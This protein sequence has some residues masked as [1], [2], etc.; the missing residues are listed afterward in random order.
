MLYVRRIMMNVCRR[1]SGNTNK[2]AI[3]S[4]QM[5]QSHMGSKKQ[6]YLS[7]VLKYAY[8][9]T[10]SKGKGKEVKGTGRKSRALGRWEQPDYFLSFRGGCVGGMK[11]KTWKNLKP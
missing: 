8:E 11:G 4:E 10:L 9:C 1:N 3:M 2:R 5:E 7:F 6:Q